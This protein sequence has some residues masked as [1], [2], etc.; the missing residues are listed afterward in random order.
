MFASNL[1]LRITNVRTVLPASVSGHEENRSAV[2]ENCPQTKRRLFEKTFGHR[3]PR[4]RN[5]TSEKKH[6]VA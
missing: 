3:L 4:A 5:I 6:F 2:R 1:E